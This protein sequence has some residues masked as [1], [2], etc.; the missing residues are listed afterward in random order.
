MKNILITIIKDFLKF[1]FVFPIKKN[2]ILFS[3]YSGKNYSCNPKYI[4]EYLLNQYGDYLEIVWAFKNP[5]QDKNLD[6][7]IKVIRFKSVKYI[8]YLLTS[9]VV[10]D[11][12]ESWSILPKRKNQYII[13]FALSYL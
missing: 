11:N 8:Y 6:K 1:F 10:V 12:V 4:C 9:K 7:R 3:S 5:K 2:R 13:I